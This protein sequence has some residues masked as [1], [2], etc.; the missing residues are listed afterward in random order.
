MTSTIKSGGNVSVR[1]TGDTRLEG[2]QI[3]SKGDT[4]IDAGGN[5][6]LDAAR[7]TSQSASDSLD[8]SGS[9]SAS[10]TSAGGSFSVDTSNANARSSEAV[11]GSIDA[12]GNLTVK[13][14]KDVKV[15]GADLSAG[16]D[17]TVTA[18]GK[19]ELKSYAESIRGV[20]ATPPQA[21]LRQP[22]IC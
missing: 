14:G 8:I 6:T 22:C 11:T 15:E 16:E 3:Q 12:G 13:S 1:T 10:K 18:E 7:N 2:T 17:A 19:V 4:T 20:A 21:F 5:V 9:I